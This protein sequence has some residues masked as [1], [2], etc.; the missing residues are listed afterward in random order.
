[1]GMGIN[2]IVFYGFDPAH[3]FLAARSIRGLQLL[4][5]LKDKGVNRVAVQLDNHRVAYMSIR[6]A[7]REMSNL[8]DIEALNGGRGF[9]LRF[10]GRF[11]SFRP[12]KIDYIII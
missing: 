10:T 4:T 8:K 2:R 3:R 5:R 9:A 6:Y 1:M 7:G 11:N 12:T